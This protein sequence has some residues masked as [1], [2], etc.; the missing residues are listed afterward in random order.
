MVNNSKE[1]QMSKVF[2][3]NV[4]RNRGSMRSHSGTVAELIEVFAYTLEVGASYAHEKGNS[5]INRTPT[6]AK[7]LVSNLNKATNNAA[8]N[9]YSGT[10][11]EL[12]EA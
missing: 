8:A 7:G 2:T 10:R 11:Y 1:Q 4:H 6:T 3:I 5:K 12:A 9:G